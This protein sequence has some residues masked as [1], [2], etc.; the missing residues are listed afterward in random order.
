MSPSTTWPGHCAACI[1]SFRRSP[2]RRSCAALAARSS[3]S[4]STCGP[5]ARPSS[6][7]LGGLSADNGSGAVRAGAVRA[8]LPDARRRDRDELLRR[9]VLRARDRR[10]PRATTIRGWRLNGRCRSRSS[11]R[12]TP[13]GSSSTRSSTTSAAAWPLEWR[14]ARDHR[15]HGA[16]ARAGQGHPIRVGMVGAGFMGQGLANQIVNSVPGMRLVGI[17]N[18]IR[19][20]PPQP[21]AMRGSSRSRQRPR[22]RSRTR[23]APEAPFSQ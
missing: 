14:W 23:S 9:R 21:C 19:N 15:R 18:R 11:P 22:T 6:E 7:H 4:S 2:R 8:R 17:S 1:S 13:S 10:R 5:R 20:A 3:T 16:C 12:R